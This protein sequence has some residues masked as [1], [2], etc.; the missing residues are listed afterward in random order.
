MRRSSFKLMMISAMNENGG[1]TLHRLF[2]GHPQLFVYPFESQLGTRLISDYFAT[3]FQH[4]YRWPQF[5]LEGTLSGDYEQIWDQELKT[6]IRTPKTSKFK[7]VNIELNDSERKRIFLG[8]LKHRRRTRR[9]VIEA[10][11]I[12]TFQ[13]WRNY[14]TS[15]KEKIYL[16][17]SPIVVVDSDTILDDFPDAKIIHIV[18]NPFSSYADTIYRPVP[19]P[20]PRY[21]S[22]WS[23]VQNFA[24]SFQAL[25]PKNVLVVRFEDLIKDP[26]KFFRPLCRKLSISYSRTLT[27]PSW[28]G[29]RLEQVYPWGTIRVPTEEVNLESARQLRKPEIQE[30]YLRTKHFLKL[31]RYEGFYQRIK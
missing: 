10:F 22:E 9:N 11:F 27:Y 19:L 6:R 17:Y 20:L 13:A 15:G 25:Y 31:L 26:E 4:K 7:D 3:V 1:N 21:I 14:Q 16:G 2:D 18:R 29:E 5:A 12:A 8:V 30:I 23:I 28:N 24:L